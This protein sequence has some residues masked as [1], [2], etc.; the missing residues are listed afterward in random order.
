MTGIL[1]KVV[2]DERLGAT[3][4][5]GALLA[6]MR[7]SDTPFHDIAC[8]VEREDL[9]PTV[10]QTRVYSKANAVADLGRVGEGYANTVDSRRTGRERMH[11]V[12]L[13]T[14]LETWDPNNTTAWRPDS[15]IVDHRHSGLT[16]HPG[17]PK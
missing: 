12:G 4:D 6:Y 5:E 2:T 13:R 15:A 11:C 17:V 7:P 9:F 3:I 10:E 14:A 16:W 8:D 1:P